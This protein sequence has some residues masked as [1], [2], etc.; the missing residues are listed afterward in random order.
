MP[1]KEQL[2]AECIIINIPLKYCHAPFLLGSGEGGERGLA[3]M[4]G[5]FTLAIIEAINPMLKLNF[6]IK[7]HALLEG[8]I[9]F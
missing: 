7:G 3:I 2:T 4:F 6:Q 5:E 8:L 1:K 9:L